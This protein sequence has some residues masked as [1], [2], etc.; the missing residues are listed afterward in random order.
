MQQVASALRQASAAVAPL[1]KLVMLT[2][3]AG[4]YRDI[5]VS[6]EALYAQ[7]VMHQHPLHSSPLPSRPAAPADPSLC[8]TTFP[9]TD[10]TELPDNHPSLQPPGQQLDP[11]YMDKI[12]CWAQTQPSHVETSRLLQTG[13]TLFPPQEA[14]HPTFVDLQAAMKLLDKHRSRKRINRIAKLF[15]FQDKY[16]LRTWQHHVG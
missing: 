13:I 2:S 12:T 3:L 9:I 10:S 6:Q 11:H 5:L 15:K 8:T 1:H 14:S 16:Q 7:Q 4:H